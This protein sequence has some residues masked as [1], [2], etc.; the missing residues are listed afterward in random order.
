MRN[1][2]TILTFILISS[3]FFAQNIGIGTTTPT[4]NLDINGN[5]KVTKTADKTNDTNFKYLLA[6]DKNTGN[7]DFITIPALDQ[8]ESKNVEISRNIYIQNSPLDS[9]T[10]SCGEISFYIKN[11]DNKTYFKL[12][13]LK[14]F[15]I[16][17]EGESTPVNTITLGYGVKKWIG[18]N[19]T[20]SDITGKV[21]TTSNFAN[22]QEIEAASFI[23]TDA[24]DI[25]VYTIV[26]P[27]QHNL[28]R[29]TISK[30]SNTPTIKQFSLICEK[31]YIKE[32]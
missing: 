31:F 17:S 22:Y 27:K 13:S 28:Y 3:K 18:T 12:N 10:C 30:L 1:K 19:Y 21:F 11:S 29:L 7:L 9:E 32:I 20:Y 23:L 15:E 8:N 26:L 5:L 16:A 14:S 2:Y 24:S 4:R 25:R 6:T